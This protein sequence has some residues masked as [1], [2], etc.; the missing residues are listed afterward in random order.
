M[1][2]KRPRSEPLLMDASE[3]TGMLVISAANGRPRPHLPR[4]TGHSP[5]G[6]SRKLIWLC[7]SKRRNLILSKV[8]AK[9]IFPFP[10]STRSTIGPSCVQLLAGLQPAVKSLRIQASML[11]VA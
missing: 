9:V 7:F 8:K 4:H 10:L 2:Q 1:R 5:T 3:Y 11:A 6:V